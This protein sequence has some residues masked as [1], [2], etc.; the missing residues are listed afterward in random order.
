LL[1]QSLGAALD[2]L[3]A[4]ATVSAALGDTLMREFVALKRHEQ[5]A[6]ARHVSD[7]EMQ[8]YVTAF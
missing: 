3:E 5:T 6:Y 8:R 2:A 1:P 7:W 4:D